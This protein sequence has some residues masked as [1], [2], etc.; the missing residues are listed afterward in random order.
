[1]QGSSLSGHESLK[2]GLGTGKTIAQKKN[3]TPYVMHFIHF[4]R[5]SCRFQCVLP[6]QLL[7]WACNL[8]CLPKQARGMACDELQ[9]LRLLHRRILGVPCQSMSCAVYAVTVSSGSKARA[10]TSSPI[11]P[12]RFLASIAMRRQRSSYSRN[13]SWGM[14]I[15]RMRHGNIALLENLDSKRSLFRYQND[16][17]TIPSYSFWASF[18]GIPRDP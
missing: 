9:S 6:S 1:M 14:E 12:W 18:L 5:G 4:I 11:A 13:T 2:T 3:D 8:H 10:R 15:L 7:Q 16:T 17:K